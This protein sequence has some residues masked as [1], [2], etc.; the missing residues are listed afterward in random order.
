MAS[1]LKSFDPIEAG[2]I[3]ARD[4]RGPVRAPE[5]GL[6]LMP[7]YQAQGEDGF[8][9]GRELPI[10]FSAARERGAGRAP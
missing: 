4:R 7:R 5:A 1:G 10:P 8:F 6:M 9:V 3:V 2:Q